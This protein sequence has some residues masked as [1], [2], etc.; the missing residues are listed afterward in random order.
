MRMRDHGTGGTRVII[1][2]QDG[3]AVEAVS[4]SRSDTGMRV[5]LSGC[6]DVMEFE[7]WNGLWVSENLDPVQILFE[8]EQCKPA[9]VVS[10]AECICP[11][12]LASSLIQWLVDGDQPAAA[13]PASDVVKAA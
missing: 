1:I 2:Y 6:D 4:L 8:L 3:T 13:A 12:E 7:N 11:K 10:E 9:K 5:A